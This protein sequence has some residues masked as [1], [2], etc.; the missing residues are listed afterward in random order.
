MTMTRAR[1]V[2]ILWAAFTRAHLLLL[3][4]TLLLILLPDSAEVASGSYAWAVLIEGND[5][6][7][8]QPG[9]KPVD[10][11]TRQ[12]TSFHQKLQ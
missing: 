1:D 5:W 2:G 6:N 8:L 3:H 11:L 7:V 12:A 9:E 10:R 4:T